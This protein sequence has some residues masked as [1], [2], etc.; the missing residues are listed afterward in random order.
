ME[1][2]SACSAST[3]EWNGP[4]PAL[5]KP[6]EAVGFALLSLLLS[7]PPEGEKLVNFSGW[8]SLDWS[9]QTAWS[10]G[11]SLNQ[12]HHGVLVCKAHI[13]ARQVEPGLC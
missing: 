7:H 10:G 8:S 5:L 6:F 1:R 3:G 12:G 2:P 13:P 9:G 11:T 4:T